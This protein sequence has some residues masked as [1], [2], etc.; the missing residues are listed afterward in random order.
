MFHFPDTDE[1]APLAASRNKENGQT[2]LKAEISTSFY[3]CVLSMRTFT[4]LR[5]LL[6]WPSH[7]PVPARATVTLN[8]FFQ[9]V[10]VLSLP[11]AVAEADPRT[12]HAHGSQ[13]GQGV[14]ARSPEQ[15][16]QGALAT[17]A[18]NAGAISCREV[19]LKAVPATPAATAAAAVAAGSVSSQ[20][21]RLGGG[22]RVHRSA[23]GHHPDKAVSCDQTSSEQRQGSPERPDG[24]D[25]C[26]GGDRS[27]RG[28]SGGSGDGS[29]IASTAAAS[30]EERTVLVAESPGQLGIGGKVWDSAFVLC[31]YLA[32]APA[33]IILSAAA[34]AT[35]AAVDAAPARTT[36]T[37]PKTSA[38][39]AAGTDEELTCF[40]S[41]GGASGLG[42]AAGSSI[43]DDQ[44]E[45]EESLRQG[46]TGERLSA[47]NPGCLSVSACSSADGSVPR[48]D[49]AEEGG[50]GD[51]GGGKGA[52]TP[53]KGQLQGAC[54][55]SARGIVEGRRVLE[56]G[57]GTGLVSVCCALLGASAV[58]ATDFDVR[59]PRR[60][61]CSRVVCA[62]L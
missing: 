57:A 33:S 4:R 3:W 49:G 19:V 54:V 10:P 45:Q 16:E 27:C 52:S 51:G 39:T 58:V 14:E 44:A 30:L 2:L 40:A 22:V 24:V 1:L 12:N 29:V 28:G 48:G 25:G 55:A 17:N 20:P 42:V 36:S 31:D 60:W 46:G 7:P 8:L 53:A 5:L 32:K 47:S 11:I 43:D 15:T 37:S 38:R 21:R 9:V 26:G 62:A 34:A 23:N 61:R 59:F 18:F 6:L 41:V 50:G 56:L 13:V 35:A